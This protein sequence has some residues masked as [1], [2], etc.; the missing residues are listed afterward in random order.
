MN[1]KV[2][3]NRNIIFYVLGAGTSS[4][5][6]V[7]SGLAF[8]FLAYDLTGSS[9][10]TTGIAISQ[11]IPYLLFGLVGGVF[12]DW[13]NKKSL[14][15]LIDFVRVPVIFSIVLSYQFGV[16]DY[17]YLIVVSFLIQT[18]G[19]F[20]N[21]AHRAILPIITKEDERTTTNSLLD[22]VT[23]G[24]QVLSP[25]VVVGFMHTIGEIH[26]FTLDAITYLIS[27]FFISK[28]QIKED[29][30]S[31]TNSNKISHIFPSIKEFY[32]WLKSEVSIKML[33]IVTFVMVFFN[34]WV[35]QVGL[36]LQIIE[37]TPD[38]EEWYSILLGWYGVAV[39]ITNILIPFLW[40]E[41]TIKIYFL[42]SIIWG[43]GI[44]IL[45]FSYHLPLYFLGVFITAMGVPIASLSRVYL[46]Q[47]LLPNDKLGR[48]FSFNA[49]LLYFSN[50]VSL[51]LFGYLSSFISTQVLFKVC[52]GLMLLF[53]GLHF[54][55][56]LRKDPGVSPYRRLNS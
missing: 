35:W 48:G 27:A 23:R 16:L 14:L 37:T 20:F 54:F 47:K 13:V 28:I 17:W 39:V 53:T 11:A 32:I 3:K 31:L 33:F 50:V 15:I 34:T 22:T 18:L 43:S 41:M 24:V 44:V 25:V 9:I 29:N 42:G 1:I 51:G 4:L 30:K 21:P 56:F 36:L 40:K 49:V 10:H 12:A 45:G 7:V 8:L 46:L 55:S 2:L 19:C 52:G 26:F 38:G 5:G 6:D